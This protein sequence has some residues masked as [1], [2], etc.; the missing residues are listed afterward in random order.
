MADKIP[1]LN[2]GAEIDGASK[3]F[4]LKID[5]PID[6]NNIGLAV[7]ILSILA[8]E[9]RDQTLNENF[10][11]EFAKIHNDIFDSIQNPN[12]GYL[13]ELVAYIDENGFITL[14]QGRIINPIGIGVEP[15]DAMANYLNTDRMIPGGIPPK[16]LKNNSSLLWITKS[17]GKLTAKSIN[18]NFYN[19][20]ISL[21]HNEATKRKLMGNWIKLNNETNLKEIQIA[22]L[23]AEKEK[24]LKKTLP[25]EE[26]KAKVEKLTNEMRQ[27]QEKTNELYKQ[28]QRTQEEMVNSQKL[29]N[30][31]NAISTVAGLIKS[32]IQLNQA[33][34]STNTPIKNGQDNHLLSLEESKTIVDSRLTQLGLQ[35]A[36]LTTTTKQY[37]DNMGAIHTVLSN[38][39]HIEVQPVPNLENNPLLILQP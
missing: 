18:N 27:L 25:N 20:F 26:T 6:L 9:F 31:L 12:T 39:Y 34:T 38:E 13:L 24:Q 23:W 32:G 35:N 4:D 28:Y 1:Q 36:T 33:M 5:N 14:P 11:M 7:D 16:N 17:E 21:S 10:N 3:T 2:L 8:I 15:L 22:E 30:T 29:A 19:K 37:L